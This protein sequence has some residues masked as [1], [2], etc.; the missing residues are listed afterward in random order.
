MPNHYAVIDYTPCWEPS[1]PTCEPNCCVLSVVP[2]A[3]PHPVQPT[4]SLRAIATFAI[5]SPDAWPG[6]RTG[7]PSDRRTVTW[8]ASPSR[9]RN[10]ALPCLLMWPIQRHR[11]WTLPPASAPHSYPSACASKRSGVPITNTN[12]SA[13]IGPTPGCVLSRRVSG[14][15]HCLFLDPFSSSTLGST[16]SS[17]S[18]SSCRRRLVHAASDNPSNSA[19]PAG[20]T[21]RVCADPLV[22]CDHLQLVHDPRAHLHQPMAMP[23]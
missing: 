6:E 18:S 11:R 13:V 7:A 22:H 16:R 2:A 12:A 3:P 17:N 15:V 19:R 23:H 10:S 1:S 4:A 14:R 9:K 8:A 20:S 5:A 21:T